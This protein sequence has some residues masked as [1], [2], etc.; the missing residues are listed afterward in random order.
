MVDA[1][2]AVKSA[3]RTATTPVALAPALAIHKADFAATVT[4]TSIATALAS[5]GPV[6]STLAGLP[7]VMDWAPCLLVG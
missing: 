2:P 7:V 3:R 6:A 1:D 5:I 4:A